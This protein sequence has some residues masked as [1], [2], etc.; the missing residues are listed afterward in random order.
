MA[1]LRYDASA[2]SQV[3]M[4]K[5]AGRGTLGGSVCGGEGFVVPSAM[6]HSASFVSRD[7][8]I[9]GLPVEA[10]ASSVIFTMTGSFVAFVGTEICSTARLLGL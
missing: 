4:R 1:R 8:R 5:G 3:G 7:T 10:G 2:A 6:V 9:V